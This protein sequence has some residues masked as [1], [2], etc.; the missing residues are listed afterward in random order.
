MVLLPRE[1]VSSSWVQLARV[2]LSLDK[3]QTGLSNDGVLENV[4]LFFRRFRR[5]G[6]NKVSHTTKNRC[7]DAHE[8]SRGGSLEL[9]DSYLILDR[10]ALKFPQN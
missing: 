2:A 9:L 6:G 1:C 10:C 3:G 7:S 8:E 5:K 4:L